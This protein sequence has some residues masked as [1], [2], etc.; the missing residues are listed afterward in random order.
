MIEESTLDNVDPVSEKEEADE[1]SIPQGTLHVDIKKIIVSEKGLNLYENGYYGSLDEEQQLTLNPEEGL[2]LLE[3]SK[4]EVIDRS[5]KTISPGDLV[6]FVSR[7]DPTFFSRYLVYKD[8]RNRGYVVR[9]G[10]GE[11]SPYRLYSRGGIP[12]KDSSKSVVYP[13]AEGKDMD[14]KNLDLVVNQARMDRKKL[15][16]GVIDRLGDVTYYL[17]SQLTLEKNPYEYEFKDESKIEDE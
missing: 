13:L 9:P 15:L 11:F 16:L 5:G 1:E 2:L 8:L 4:L 12:G 17:A 6:G 7:D 10:F 3:R 14:L